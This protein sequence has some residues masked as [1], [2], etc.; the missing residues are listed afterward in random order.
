MVFKTKIKCPFCEEQAVLSK[1]SL[2]FFNGLV[3][4]SDAPIYVCTNCK[5]EF[6]TGKIVDKTLSNAK[7]MFS[8][9]RQLI[10][11]GGSLGLTFPPDL[12]RYYKLEKGEKVKLVPKSEKEIS[13]IIE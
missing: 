8:F 6:A 2:N 12:S 1:T 3:S 5:E 9:T 10:S 11:T 13:V 7:K 4:I